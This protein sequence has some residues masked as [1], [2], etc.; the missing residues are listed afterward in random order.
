MFREKKPFKFRIKSNEI[1]EL[2]GEQIQTSIH[3]HVF[4]EYNQIVTD[5]G[6]Q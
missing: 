1:N 6:G 4:T 2:R 5:I 3:L